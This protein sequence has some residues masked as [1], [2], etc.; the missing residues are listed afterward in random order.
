[1]NLYP[2]LL[3]SILPGKILA[4]QV[5][6]TRTA[7][8][9]ETDHGIQCGLA[10]TL[11]NPDL[12]H[13]NHPMVRNAGHLQEMSDMELAGLIESS[14]ITEAS[15]GLAAINALLPQNPN[16]WMDL[17]A[18][19]YVTQQGADRNVAVVGH[20]PF[21]YELRPR[22]KNLWVLELNPRDGDLPAHMAPEILPQADLVAITATSLINK[23]FQGLIKLCRP[24]AKVVLLG[25]ST[26]LSPVL[27]DHGVSVIAGTIVTDTNKTLLGVGQGTSLHQLRQAGAV[28]LVTLQNKE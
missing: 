2:Q 15:I 7:V 19:A 28:R 12:D 5:G 18:E 24:G 25:P 17:N 9:V 1:M 6:L 27:Y 21:V 10:A 16:L 3:Q 22:V 4:V 14:S 26:P 23:T 8:L 20:F 13:H 11:V